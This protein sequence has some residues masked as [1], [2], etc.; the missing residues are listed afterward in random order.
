LGG[1]KESIKKLM[2][3]AKKKVLIAY[4][5]QSGQ[6]K[7]I[8]DQ[9]ISPFKSDENYEFFFYQIQPV[10]DY[11]FPWTSQQFFDSFPESVTEVGCEIKT[12]PSPLKQ[13]YDMVVLG[14]QTWYLSPSIPTMAF[15]QS[16]EFKELV[17]DTPVITINACRNMWFMAQRSIRKY[18]N[19]ANAKYIG[20]LVL[21]DKVNNLTSVVTI[22]HWSF[23]GKKDK[24]WGWLPKPGISDTDIENSYLFGKLLK[25][26]WESGQLDHLQQEYINNKGVQVLPHLM[27]MEHKA[28]RIFKIWT[29]Y[30]LKKGGPGNPQRQGRL[31]MFKNY[32]LLMIFLMAPIATLVFYLTYPLFFIRIRRNVKFYQ[33]VS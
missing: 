24:K 17:Q 1:R 10:N 27:S 25:E 21:F 9:F 4:Y 18:L 7:E 5:T 30:V 22:M 14:F 33:S 12:F 16:S 11:P 20:H 23:T 19:E 32:L 29:K 13:K 31:K 6:L 15:L 28:K 26:N 3:M 2:N 8:L